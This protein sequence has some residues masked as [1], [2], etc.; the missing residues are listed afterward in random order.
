MKISSRVN[1]T[2][3]YTYVPI[4]RVSLVQ[5][6]FR[7]CRASTGVRYPMIVP[8]ID[9]PTTV[10]RRKGRRER[11]D[12]YTHF[13]ETDGFWKGGGGGPRI[14][15]EFQPRLLPPRGQRGCFRAKARRICGVRRDGRHQTPRASNSPS[16][17]IAWRHTND[18][19][20]A[21]R[22][23]VAIGKLVSS[24]DHPREEHPSLPL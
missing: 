22:H 2:P 8:S 10:Q 6:T 17:C 20:F 16:N 12:T 5:G 14:R 9:P 4:Y 7:H 13:A 1:F 3:C 15:L 19:I 24:R 11:P 18:C 21:S 23:R